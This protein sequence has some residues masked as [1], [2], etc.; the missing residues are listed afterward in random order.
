MFSAEKDGGNIPVLSTG[1]GLFLRIIGFVPKELSLR[2][3]N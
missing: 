1:A 2:R 3:A